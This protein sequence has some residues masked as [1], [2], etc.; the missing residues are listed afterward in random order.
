MCLALCCGIAPTCSFHVGPQPQSAPQCSKASTPSPPALTMVLIIRRGCLQLGTQGQDAQE[1][2]DGGLHVGECHRYGWTAWV[3]GVY[4]YVGLGRGHAQNLR[5]PK[6]SLLLRVT[7]RGSDGLRNYLLGLV[8]PWQP[9]CSRGKDPQQPHGKRE[10]RPWDGVTLES[11]GAQNYPAVT[12]DQINLWDRNPEGAAQEDV[13]LGAAVLAVCHWGD[14]GL[15]VCWAVP[16]PETQR[17]CLS[18]SWPGACIMPH[19][20]MEP[21][22][23][24]GWVPEGKRGL[25]GSRVWEGSMRHKAGYTRC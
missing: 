16:I 10:T 22:G 9:S 1:Q 18:R 5:V 17:S 14:M 15:W 19:L 3:G 13:P 4:I 8:Q 20:L 21:Q 25:R 11:W 23:T 2:N 24:T 7:A 12:S 6:H